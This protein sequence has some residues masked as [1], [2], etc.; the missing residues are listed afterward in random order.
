MFDRRQSKIFRWKNIIILKK[1]DC[2]QKTKSYVRKF[3]ALVEKPKSKIFKQIFN[4][5]LE[6]FMFQ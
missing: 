2:H 4:K 1:I 5:K 3:K 6:K